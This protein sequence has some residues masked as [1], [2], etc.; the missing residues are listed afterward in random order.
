MKTKATPGPWKVDELGVITCG[1]RG[2]CE[3]VA[4]TMYC[5]WLNSQA[6]AASEPRK[7]FDKAEW[8][9]KQAETARAN[10]FLIAAA[11]D[12][13]GACRGLLDM[14][15]DNRTHGPE[16]DTAC[17]AIAKAEAIPERE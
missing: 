15:T 8:C 5:R 4:E 7:D 11:P 9:G 6:Y 12:L 3:T 2:A 13:L 10:G 1:I 14:I 16:I 17:A